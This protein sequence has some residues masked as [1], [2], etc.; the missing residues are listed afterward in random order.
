MCKD[1]FCFCDR[2]RAPK[3]AAIAYIYRGKIRLMGYP[4]PDDENHNC[5][6]MGCSSVGPHVLAICD[7]PTELFYKYEPSS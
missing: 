1:D 2:D 6:E 4:H 7:I 3:D 5:D